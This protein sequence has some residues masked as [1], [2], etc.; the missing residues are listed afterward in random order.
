[1]D[2]NLIR[3]RFVHVCTTTG[4]RQV[5]GSRRLVKSLWLIVCAVGLIAKK[6]TEWNIGLF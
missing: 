2:F 3:H 4:T 5:D 6:D 1:M